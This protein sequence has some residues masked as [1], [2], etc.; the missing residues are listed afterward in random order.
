MLGQ[1]PFA[2]ALRHPALKLIWLQ[3]RLAIVA[4]T[5]HLTGVLRHWV[6]NADG[7]Q[8]APVD[9]EML[10]LLQWHGAEEVGHREVAGAMF[11]HLSNNLLL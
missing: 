4:A 6:L 8:Q 5:E 1:K 11:W 9:E 2:Y 7:L 10:R 3:T